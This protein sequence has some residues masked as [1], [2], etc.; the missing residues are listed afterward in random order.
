MVLPTRDALLVHIT[1]VHPK[2]Q[3]VKKPE[4]VRNV[5]KP[6][7]KREEVGIRDKDQIKE[8]ER[9]RERR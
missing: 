3:I 9:E 6:V 5:L 8:R 4:I 1:Y 2:G 7:E